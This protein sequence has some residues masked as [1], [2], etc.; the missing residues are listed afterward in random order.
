MAGMIRT[1][2]Q[3]M[4]LPNEEKEKKLE[5]L[6]AQLR[7]YQRSKYEPPT[8]HA[9]NWSRGPPL[10]DTATLKD[11]EPRIKESIWETW[12]GVEGAFTTGDNV[13]DETAARQ[14]VVLDKRTRAE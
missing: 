4:V 6:H 7:K 8:V 11:F 5:W 1:A 13:Y 12:E 3:Q 14:G 2:K 10:P 9:S